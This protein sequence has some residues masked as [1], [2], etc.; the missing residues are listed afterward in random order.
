MFVLW[1]ECASLTAS[2]S[3]RRI[4]FLSLPRKDYLVDTGGNLRCT[5]VCS[6]CLY[7]FCGVQRHLSMS[8]EVFC[9]RCL[10]SM[11]FQFLYNCCKRLVRI[12]GN[13]SD[14]FPVGVGPCLVT[15]QG[16]MLN[17]EFFDVQITEPSADYSTSSVP[18]EEQE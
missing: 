8:L 1:S 4:A 17:W 10:K 11:G 3:Y 2:S 12:A 9:V 16:Q 18:S 5:G 6:T 15:S 14:S 7:V 13:N